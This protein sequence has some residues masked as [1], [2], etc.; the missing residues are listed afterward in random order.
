MFVCTLECK[1]GRGDRSYKLRFLSQDFRCLS[2]TVFDSLS[3]CL[4]VCLSV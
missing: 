2:D 4:T 1:T 3:E